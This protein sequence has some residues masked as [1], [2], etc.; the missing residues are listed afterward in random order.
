[1]F[2]GKLIRPFATITAEDVGN[3]IRAV[4][5]LCAHGHKNIV[6]VRSHYLL[7]NSP[8]YAI[9]MEFCELTLADYI[10]GNRELVATVPVLYDSKGT[11]NYDPLALKWHAIG[12]IMQHICQG[13]SFI[14]S[15]NE[16]HRD[17]KPSNSEFQSIIHRLIA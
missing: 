10:R 8:Y 6:N 17:L 11:A 3:E 5:K 1:M 12:T 16:I 4:T 9:D 13:L 2:A 15:C 14:H 7:Q